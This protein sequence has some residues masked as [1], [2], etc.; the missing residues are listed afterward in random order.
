M[1]EAEV[2]WSQLLAQRRRYGIIQACYTCSEAAHPV[3]GTS[4]LLSTGMMCRWIN[5]TAAVFC[6]FLLTETGRRE[7]GAGY[8]ALTFPRAVQGDYRS[9]R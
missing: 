9:Q 3:C 4:S 1:F 5:G 7:V 6:Y 8:D 2:T